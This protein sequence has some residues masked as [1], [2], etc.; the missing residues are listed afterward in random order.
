MTQVQSQRV[1]VRGNYFPPRTGGTTCGPQSRAYYQTY[2]LTGTL[3]YD[4]PGRGTGNGENDQG[5]APAP[6]GGHWWVGLG[7]ACLGNVAY[8]LGYVQRLSAQ[9]DTVKGWWLGAAPPRSSATAVRARGGTLVVAGFVR[10]TGGINQQI[11]QYRLTCLDTLTGAI[12]WQRDYQNLPKANDYCMALAPTPRG[13]YLLSGD[14]QV[15]GFQHYLL[16]TDSVGLFRRK[17]IFSPLG[18]NF[19]G[20]SRYNYSCNILVLPNA[21][22]YLLSGTADSAVTGTTKSIGYVVRL[23]TALNVVWTYRHPPGLNGSN[24]RS[25]AAYKIRLLPNGTVGLMLVD[26]RSTY[27]GTYLVQLNVSTGQR[28]AF[29]ALPSNTQQGYMPYDWQ[30]VG[31]GTLLVCGKSY[32]VGLTG[33]QGYLARF[34]FRG[35]PLATARP[36]AALAGGVSLWAYPNPAGAATTLQ[37]HGLGRRAATVQLLDLAGRAARTLAVPGDGD[38][39]LDLAGLPAGVYLVRLLGTAG[40]L[41]GTCKVVVV[42]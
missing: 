25:Q 39:A 11:Q 14:S 13:G 27:F 36:A 19:D 32:Q 16:E 15:F 31:D 23:D 17:R 37:V 28:V 1:T 30:W 10:P 4:R 5:P 41:L 6:G 7:A 3:L 29:Y 8:T 38:H 42:P 40:R 12:R 35:T 26:V 21:G 9:G 34:D 20:G 22:G 24:V 2:D 18:P 33:Q